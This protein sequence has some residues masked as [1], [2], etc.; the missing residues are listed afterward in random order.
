M[1]K[2]IEKKPEGEIQECFVIMP[3]DRKEGYA[4][5]HFYKVYRNIFVPAIEQA[6]YKPHR[7]DD[8]LESGEINIEILTKLVNAP[9][10]ICDISSHNPNVMYELGMRM[11]FDLPVVTVAEKGTRIPFD[12]QSKRTVYYDNRNDYNEVLKDIEAI[13]KAIEATSKS[14]APSLI[15]MMGL[16]TPAKLKEIEDDPE[17]NALLMVMARL[18]QL[19]KRLRTEAGLSEK[20]RIEQLWKGDNFNSNSDLNRSLTLSS[21]KNDALRTWYSISDDQSLYS[22]FKDFIQKENNDSDD[23][24]QLK[25][26]LLMRLARRGVSVVDSNNDLGLLK[27]FSKVF[28]VK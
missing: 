10:A 15:K 28:M 2:A 16:S 4:D 26:E 12:F 8:G 1:A 18:D 23:Y 13:T 14:D 27:I 25:A 7:A 17:G 22:E 9:L 6:G 3:F 24:H 11:A 19:E 21:A 20:A 5:N